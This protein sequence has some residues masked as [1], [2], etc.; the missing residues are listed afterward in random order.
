M[1]KTCE[2]FDGGKEVDVP[3]SQCDIH[4]VAALIRFVVGASM[5][6][7]MHHSKFI[8]LGNVF[9]KNRSL[10][11]AAAAQDAMTQFFDRD[12][13]DMSHV[14][15]ATQTTMQ[16]MLSQ[17]ENREAFQINAEVAAC[18]PNRNGDKYRDFVLPGVIRGFSDTL[19]DVELGFAAKPTKRHVQLP[20]TRLRLHVPQEVS[21]PEKK[22]MNERLSRWLL[23]KFIHRANRKL[24]KLARVKSIP[25]HFGRSHP[26][27][28]LRT[29]IAG[30]HAPALNSPTSQTSA[31]SNGTEALR[32]AMADAEAG[33]ARAR[34]VYERMVS[35]KATAR[36]PSSEELI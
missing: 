31:D 26:E 10:T 29:A 27:R 11:T 17:E 16:E 4:Q 1:K 24:N 12:S 25:A 6:D 9:L 35:A 3:E 8:A 13:D 5:I 22:Q 28:E 14:T 23:Q 21:E 32:E 18:V 19:V 20:L 2:A 33:M 15:A 30:G 36:G 7:D 34:T